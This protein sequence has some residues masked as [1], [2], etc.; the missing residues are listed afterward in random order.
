MTEE[1]AATRRERPSS[2]NGPLSGVEANALRA[3]T[4]IASSTK[5]SRKAGSNHS[6]R[7]TRASWRCGSGPNGLA[8]KVQSHVATSPSVFAY[9][10]QLPVSKMGAGR[11]SRV[12][13]LRMKPKLRQ[14]RSALARMESQTIISQSLSLTSP[15]FAPRRAA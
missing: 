11:S 12:S 7:S 5:P 15:S 9:Q 4:A 3:R 6:A 2:M 8:E 14:W 13:T 1:T 10:R